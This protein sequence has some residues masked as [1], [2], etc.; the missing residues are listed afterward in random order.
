MEAQISPAPGSGLGMGCA[1]WL[2]HYTFIYGLTGFVISL[3]P[4]WSEGC[5]HDGLV[6][7]AGGPVRA[8]KLASSLGLA[9]LTYTILRCLHSPAHRKGLALARSS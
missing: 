8:A 2:F 9:L 3:S 6:Q 7:D 1:S 5:K 4:A